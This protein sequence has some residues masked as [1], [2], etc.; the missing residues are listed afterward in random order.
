M[1]APVD[2]LAFREWLRDEAVRQN[3][4]LRHTLR[5]RL[6]E[7]EKSRMKREAAVYRDLLSLMGPEEAWTED[8]KG[9]PF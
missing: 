4:M 6:R 9:N 7:C 1:S 2:P 3:E 5:E 8:K